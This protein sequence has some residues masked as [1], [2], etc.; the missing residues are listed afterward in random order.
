MNYELPSAPLSIGGVLDNAIRLY[1][2]AIP[3]CWILALIYSGVLALFTI[4]W[5][6][7]LTKTAGVA[8]TVG[9]FAVPRAD[10][11]QVFAT[12]FSGRVLLGFLITTLFSMAVY[13]AL[14]KTES[15]LARGEP[16]PSLGEALLAG[17]R[18]VPSMVLAGLL[19]ALAVCVGFIAL[20]V[21]GIY[22]F[23]KLQL[24]LV[25]MFMEDTGALGSLK[26]SW[27]LTEKRWWRA[28]TIIAVAFVLVYVVALAVGLLANVVE[29]IAHVSLGNRV[30]VNQIFSAASN[31][32]VLP[33]VVAIGVVMYHDFKLRSEGGDL[34]ARL[35]TLGKA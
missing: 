14:V 25:A 19:F 9:G 32:L 5:V 34:A 4:A 17:L 23:G 29:G 28:S 10:P 11:Q 22:I 2:Y 26:A 15:S 13:G 1:R 16:Q 3:R 35:G 12:L 18:R 31:I 6:L 33:L 7:P 21:P 24:W 27:R 30:I 20:L 8:G